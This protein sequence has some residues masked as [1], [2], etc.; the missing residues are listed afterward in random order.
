[1]CSGVSTQARCDVC[2]IAWL[3]QLCVCVVLFCV[4]PPRSLKL[5]SLFFFLFFSLLRNWATHSQ[6]HHGDDATQ[7]WNTRI[8]GKRDQDKRDFAAV[9]VVAA[10]A[11]AAA[12]S[13]KHVRGL[14]RP[15]GRSWAVHCTRPLYKAAG[16]WQFMES[17][18]QL[19]VPAGCCV[20][21][22]RAGTW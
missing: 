19:P 15:S 6:Q 16:L 8:E 13:A 22:L 17:S 12:A 3:H 14:T 9:A 4:L 5:T 1:M 21:Y 7:K 20:S 11:A 2:L 18:S 10:A